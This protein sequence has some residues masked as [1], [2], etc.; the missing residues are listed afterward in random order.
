MEEKTNS[1]NSENEQKNV[2]D[3]VN[4][5]ASSVKSET[6]TTVNDV[7]KSIKD[8]NVKKDAKKTTGFISSFLT[9]PLEKI[10]EIS[11]DSK[12]KDFKIA[13]ILLVVW[14]FAVLLNSIGS[15]NWVFVNTGKNILSILKDIL[16]PLFSVIVFSLVV[17][18]M[19][20]NTTKKSLTTIITAITTAQIPI[21]FSRV[22]NLINLFSTSSYKILNPFGVFT[23]V[24]SLV[25][26]YFTVKN[27]FN[28][29]NDS[30]FV[31]SFITVEA[32]YYIGYFIVSFLEIYLYLL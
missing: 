18:F 7:K 23:A 32:I 20:K 2:K 29:T 24:I 3:V 17:Y 11:N 9:D 31:K 6:K 13:I 14:S 21:I 1:Q 4:E 10:E 15:Q 8:V 16:A 27:L 28:E 26:T 30:K 5:V 19:Q 12:H 25:F 22:L